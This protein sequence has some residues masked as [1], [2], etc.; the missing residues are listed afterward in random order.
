[1]RH[2]SIKLTMGYYANIDAVEAAVLGNKGPLPE[3][4]NSSRNTLPE[5]TASRVSG[6]E[7]THCLQ[8]VNSP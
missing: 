8:R 3:Q 5:T 6:N 2:A 7:A 1:M 4:R